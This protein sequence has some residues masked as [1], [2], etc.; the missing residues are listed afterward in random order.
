VKIRDSATVLKKTE[1]DFFIRDEV[2]RATA[3]KKDTL[4]KAAESWRETRTEG[5]PKTF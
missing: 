5:T 2:S 3:G 1:H 4:I